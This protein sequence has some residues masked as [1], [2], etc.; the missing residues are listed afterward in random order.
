LLVEC[1]NHAR[2]IT[3]DVLL[4][5]A[6]CSVVRRG[7]T[8]S[9]LS[10]KAFSAVHSFDELNRFV[11]LIALELHRRMLGE[12]EATKRIAK[13]LVYVHTDTLVLMLVEY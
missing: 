3:T 7:A 4:L 11:K 13:S 2:V 1:F 12:F 5:P 8:K 10:A 6:H 9:L